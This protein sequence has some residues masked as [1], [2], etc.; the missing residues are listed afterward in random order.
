MALDGL[1][2]IVF[3][4]VGEMK[5]ISTKMCKEGDLGYHDNL[6]GGH[7]MSWLDEAGAT[8]AS[9]T[10]NSPRVVTVLVEKMEFKRPVKSGQL[11]EIWG[12][13]RKVGRTSITLNIEARRHNVRTDEQEIV[14]N[15]NMKFVRIDEYGNPVPISERVK[16]K[17]TTKKKEK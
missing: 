10:C 14:V 2:K 1:V 9:R 17:Y 13:V 12:A 4:K 11:I 5:L 7:M 6:F 15:T 3:L 8:M 16:R